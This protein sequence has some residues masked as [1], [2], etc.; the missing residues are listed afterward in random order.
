M[1]VDFNVRVSSQRFKALLNVRCKDTAR[2]FDTVHQPFGNGTAACP[3]LEAR[4]S[5]S[6]AAAVQ[7]M[8]GSGIK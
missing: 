6:D 3:D 2:G 8:D 5:R 7:V 1:L 4:P